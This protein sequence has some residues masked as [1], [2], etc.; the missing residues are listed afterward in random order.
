MKE[1]LLLCLQLLIALNILGLVIMALGWFLK[2]FIIGWLTW[3]KMRE[4]EKER[5]LEK[6]M[7]SERPKNPPPCSS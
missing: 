2:I 6:R 7:R 1:Y 5:D 3:D 4:E